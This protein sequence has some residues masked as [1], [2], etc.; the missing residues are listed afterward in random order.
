[1]CENNNAGYR[2]MMATGRCPAAA[3]ALQYRQVRQHYVTRPD[4]SPEHG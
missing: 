1:M 3:G 4:R 2:T